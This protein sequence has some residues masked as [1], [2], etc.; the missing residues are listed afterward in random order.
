L[1]PA[2][3]AAPPPRRRLLGIGDNTLD[4][5]LDLGL[6]FP[7]GNAVNVA[8]FARRLG[9]ASGYLGCL[10]DDAGGD[11]LYEALG[12]EGVHL[13][14]CRRRAGA[15]A[16]A[17]IGLEAGERRF[18]AADPGVRARYGLAAEDFAAIAGYEV[19]HTGINSEIDAELPRLRATGALISYDFSDKFGKASAAEA[20]PAIDIAFLS[21]PWHADEDAAALL[22]SFANAGPAIVVATRGAKGAMALAGGALYRQAAVPVRPLDTLGAGDA[23]IAAFLLAHLDGQEITAALAAGVRFA[24]TVCGAHGAFGHPRAWAISAD[25]SI[26]ERTRSER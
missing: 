13:G 17:L 1:R 22:R 20:L 15:N 2:P 26:L 6:Q 12:A 25:P 5:Y 11:H 19:V 9:A 8:V 23:F 14:L 3:G 4:T 24:A 18:L 10:G 21:C 7:G 16:R